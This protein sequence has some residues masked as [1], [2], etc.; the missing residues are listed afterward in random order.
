MKGQNRIPGILDLLVF[1]VLPEM[2]QFCSHVK[3]NVPSDAVFHVCDYSLVYLRF[4]P[5]E[6]TLNYCGFYV[7]INTEPHLRKNI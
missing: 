7:T 5:E 1:Q 6:I 4:P 3:E 2:W